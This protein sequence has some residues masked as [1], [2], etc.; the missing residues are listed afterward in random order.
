MIEMS[1][2]RVPTGPLP[3]FE[4]ASEAVLAYL[5]DELDMGLWAI[6]RVVDDDWIV[7]SS[8]VHGFDVSPGDASASRTR[9]A[10]A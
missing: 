9:S 1:A 6:T 2:P 4:R 10:S 8:E 3:D 5:Q 7:L